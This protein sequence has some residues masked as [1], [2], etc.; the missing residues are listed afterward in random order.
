MKIY[1]LYGPEEVILLKQPY[2]PNTFMDLI[3]SLSKFQ[4]HFSQM[5]KKQ[6]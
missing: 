6:S 2:N 4:W 5:Q 1:P 3:K